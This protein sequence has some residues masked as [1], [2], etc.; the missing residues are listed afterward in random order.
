VGKGDHE[1][2]EALRRG[3]LCLNVESV[4]ELEV[5]GMVAA[6]L[7]H[8]AP[9]ALRINPDVPADTHHYITTGLSENKFGIPKERLREALELCR[10][11]PWIS[12][13]GL[14]FHIGSQITTQEPF[15]TL[16][17]EASTIWEQFNIA[18]YGGTMV[19]LGGGLGIDYLDPV[20]NPI[21]D[22][23][24]FFQLF[25]DHLHLPQKVSRHFELG[26]SLTGQCGSLITRVLYVKQGNEK[27]H[28]IVDAGMTELIRPAL[29]GANH[30]IENITSSTGNK[31]FDV[32]GPICESSDCFGKD[33]I[34]PETI[35]GDLLK[36]HSCGA[37]GESMAMN[38]NLRGKIGKVY[39]EPRKSTIYDLRFTIESTIDELRLAI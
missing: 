28:V 11:H 8:V 30:R 29:Y 22:F 14:H 35:R 6:R 9:V 16:C 3:I 27:K 19:N 4:E 15:I 24:G 17:R 39:I 32:V 10:N 5:V 7:R 37:Y 33:I 26:R 1:I 12:F 13:L 18:G 36:I 31:I 23:H 2:E 34:L 20:A 21:P 38:Y 25:H